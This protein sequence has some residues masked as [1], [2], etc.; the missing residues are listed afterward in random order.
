M[1]DSTVTRFLVELKLDDQLG[2][3]VMTAAM[4][5]VTG[6]DVAPAGSQSSPPVVL[7]PARPYGLGLAFAVDRETGALRP[8]ARSLFAITRT[9]RPPF[10][11]ARPGDDGVLSIEWHLGEREFETQDNTALHLFL[12]NR[13]NYYEVHDLELSL[14]VLAPD[15]TDPE[16][17][18]R[19]DASALLSIYPAQQ[20]AHRLEPG[21]TLPF[22]CIV[23]TRGPRAGLYSLIV[24]V[25]Y[26][27]VYVYRETCRHTTAGISLP[28]R[29]HGGSE[30][31]LPGG[32]VSGPSQLE[33][34]SIAQRRLHMSEPAKK[35]L[36]PSHS[37][38]LHPIE[39]RVNL[40]GGA[41]LL[42]SYRLVKGSHVK[43]DDSWPSYGFNPHTKEI[44]CYFSS[45]DE[46]AMEIT[47]RNLSGAHL[48]HV[49]LTDVRLFEMNEDGGMGRP[50]DGDRLP[51]G[52]RYFEALPKQVYFGK[53][54]DETPSC[55]RH[56]G[57]VTRGVRP[58]RFRV[59][60]DLK[61]EI[62]DGS[63]HV[64]L[65]VNVNPD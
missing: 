58:G 16:A 50:A 57:L 52:N 10:D 12:T 34:I 32:L 9:P 23:V 47:L 28:L 48:K 40:P 39:R 64:H 19:P 41:E 37:R 15:R 4:T 61:Y 14:R 2:R 36:T 62:V 21:Q 31:P 5:D 25:S 45:A 20:T 33:P 8:D 18:L 7:G 54:D 38:V 42:V 1:S 3:T 65:P 11:P 13:S 17:T 46:A 35:E 27:L 55:T 60:F 63:A 49:Y 22:D 43:P 30:P 29:I 59:D 56:I 6:A 51:D 26:D 53:L 24:E 44:E